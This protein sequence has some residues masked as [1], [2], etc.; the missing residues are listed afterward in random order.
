M[1]K[2]LMLALLLSSYPLSGCLE[3][4]LVVGQPGSVI[5]NMEWLSILSVDHPVTLK[6]LHTST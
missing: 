5:R 6:L 4:T 1:R 2:F 3:S